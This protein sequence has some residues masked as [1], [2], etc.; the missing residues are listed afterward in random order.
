MG[1]GREAGSGSSPREEENLLVVAMSSF[2][3]ITGKARDQPKPNF[4]P[5]I[6]PISPADARKLCKITGRRMDDHNF[7]PLLEFGRRPECVRC[8]VTGTG[9]VRKEIPPEELEGGDLLHVTRDD[10][11]YV[12]PILRKEVIDKE[13]QKSFE[14][15]Q[16]L[17]KRLKS[18]GNDENNDKYFVYLLES[19]LCGIIV[20]Q[21]VEEAIR[22]GEIESLSISKNLDKA[23]FK[24]K[25]RPTMF[26]PLKESDTNKVV[27]DRRLYNGTG[28]NKETLGKQKK[29]LDDKKKKM[30][31]QRR[32][33]EDLEKAADEE[34]LNDQDRPKG[35][36]R[37][38][39]GISKEAK[40]YRQKLADFKEMYTPEGNMALYGDWKN[41]LK[42]NLD[43][44]NWDKIANVKS[45]EV[46]G[47]LPKQ[48]KLSLID[49]N[50]LTDRKRIKNIYD[51][52][53][54]AIEVVPAVEEVVIAK[55]EIPKELIEFVKM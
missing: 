9:D 44:L 29:V 11:K 49:D 23:I 3:R 34:L 26:I 30:F 1:S 48:A 50:Q 54:L 16:K 35:K 4:F 2:C 55:M 40:Q 53:T 14:D 17:L 7:V 18:T 47:P 36:A 8:R 51:P 24:M 28:Q 21:E 20:P 32:I 12:A 22:L 27:G 33:F 43:N 31:A 19:C 42:V 13:Y 25:G 37:I 38:F 10:Y 5:I 41:C 6:P 39:G 46:E 15:L 45:V 52:G